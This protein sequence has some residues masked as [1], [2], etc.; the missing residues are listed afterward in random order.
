[1]IPPH[2]NQ[3]Y[4]GMFPP[5]PT[6]SMQPIPRPP[7][8][9]PPPKT[10]ND[11]NTITSAVIESS[12]QTELNPVTTN[13]E[14]LSEKNIGFNTNV[15]NTVVPQ[16]RHIPTGPPIPVVP[17]PTK[18]PGNSRYFIIISYLNSFNLQTLTFF[19]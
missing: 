11:S 10:N 3:M 19:F 14:S 15:S 4:Q 5:P 6:H 17:L 12:F 18:F 9:P 1:M 8:P 16:P 2:S 7:P 13:I